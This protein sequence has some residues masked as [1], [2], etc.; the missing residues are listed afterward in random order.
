M[1]QFTIVNL[2]TRLKLFFFIFIFRSTMKISQWAIPA[3]A[4]GSR[5][6]KNW[7]KNRP[8][9]NAVPARSYSN[10]STLFPHQMRHDPALFQRA[11]ARYFP[12]IDGK[13]QFNPIKNHRGRVSSFLRLLI[14]DKPSF[15]TK[16]KICNPV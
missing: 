16:R 9:Y 13:R 7:N 11:E 12:E 14:L 3:A 5:L 6:D 10:L 4:V 15:T 2:K 8:L 1:D